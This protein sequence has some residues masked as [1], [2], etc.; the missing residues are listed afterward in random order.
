[1]YALKNNCMKPTISLANLASAGKKALFPPFLNFSW[2]TFRREIARSLITWFSLVHRSL[3]RL[4]KFMASGKR[5]VWVSSLYCSR[6][7]RPVSLYVLTKM[8]HDVLNILLAVNICHT[9]FRKFGAYSKTSSVVEQIWAKR[10][11]S[12]PLSNMIDDKQWLIMFLMLLIV[13]FLLIRTAY[14][15]EKNDLVTFQ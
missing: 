5:L 10:D 9:H 14:V 11:A 12:V 8:E 15:T 3:C 2:I 7:Y 4:R 1:M 13:V 6:F